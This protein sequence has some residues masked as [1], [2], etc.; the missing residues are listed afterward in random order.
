MGNIS[1]KLQR[2]FS[3]KG[4]QRYEPFSYCCLVYTSVDKGSVHSVD[5]GSVHSVDK[6]SVLIQE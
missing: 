2:S 5:K 1:V 3:R 4:N 6:G